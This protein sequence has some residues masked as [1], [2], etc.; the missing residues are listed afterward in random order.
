M[1]TNRSLS[2]ARDVLAMMWEIVTR[3]APENLFHFKTTN[4]QT[5][6]N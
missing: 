5:V 1:V 2:R 3:L 6:V 4:L